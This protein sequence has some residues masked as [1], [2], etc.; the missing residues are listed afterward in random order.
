MCS[1]ASSRDRY[2]DFPTLAVPINT[3]K[4]VASQIIDNG[5][6]EHAYLGIEGADL[7]AQLAQVLNL[8]VDEGALVQKVTSG[9][10]ADKAGLEGGDATVTED[11]QQV[12]AGG[13]VIT[14]IDGQPVS[15]MEDLISV[16]NG[17][18]PGDTVTLDVIRD[19]DKKQ[20][21]VD[22]GNRPDDATG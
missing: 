14:A 2:S 7:N 6:V 16:I 21:D 8:D 19:G 9:G 4:Q 20:I 22:L 11:G 3:A 12:R 10:P 18:D 13:D 15:G 17:K 1:F 5:Q